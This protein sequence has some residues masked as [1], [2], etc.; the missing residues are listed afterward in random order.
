MAECLPAGDRR[1]LAA[2]LMARSPRP[3]S[4][5][6]RSGEAA[7]CA[8]PGKMGDTRRS[9]VAAGACEFGLVEMTCHQCVFRKFRDRR[10]S[11]SRTAI[12]V[13]TGQWF[14]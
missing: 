3:L 5:K 1:V 9:G 13:S 7:R 4:L 10:F 12:S 2:A 11:N 14:R 6:H 8:F